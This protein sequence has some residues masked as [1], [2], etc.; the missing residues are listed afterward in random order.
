M[1]SHASR[2]ASAHDTQLQIETRCNAFE[3]AW[4]NGRN[5]HLEEFLADVAPAAR[6]QLLREL[7][8]LELFYR[9]D[10]D[11]ALLNDARLCE[12][13]PELMSEIPD[14]LKLLRERQW[15]RTNTD[16]VTNRPSSSMPDVDP[17]ISL[18]RRS[19][20]GSRGSR[21]LHIRCPH[22]SNPVELLTDTRL[23]SITCRTCGSAFSLVDSDDQTRQAPTL[24][25]I[26]RFEL[27]G[28]IG[29]GGFGTVWKA[30]D[31]ELERT[32]AVK[33]PRKGQ[34]APHEVEQ[35]LREARSAAQLRHP[36]I[37]PVHEVGREDDTIFI[38]SELIRG[39]S[40]CDWLS[41][42]T[43]GPKEAARLMATIADAVQHAHEKGIIHR[44]LKPSNMLMDELGQPHIMDF[45]LAKREV[46]EISMTLD[47][48]VL[49]TPAYMSPEQADGRG[50]WTDR[51]TD[52][53]SLGIIFFRMLTGELPFRGNAQMQIHKRITEDAPDPRGLNRFVPRDLSTI[54]LK[55][56]ERDPNRRFS[57]AKELADELRRFLGGEPI[58]SR[59][60]TRTERGIRWIKRNP[61]I[62][63]AALLTIVLAIAGPITAMVIAAQR[64]R[65][66]EL[67]KEVN[68]IIT[69]NTFDKQNEANTLAEL[70]SALDVWEGKSNP[71]SLGTAKTNEGPRK[72]FL[73]ELASKGEQLVA[74]WQS[75]ASDEQRAYGQLALAIIN[76]EAGRAAEAETHY[77]AAL[78]LLAQLSAK[79]PTETQYA[80]TIADCY[81]QLSRLHVEHDRARAA[82]DLEKSR[83]I[84]QSLAG[85]HSD[86]RLQ[87]ELLEAELDT[88][89]MKGGQAGVQNLARVQ[90]I[91]STLLGNLPKDPVKLYELTNFLAGR[92]PFLTTRKSTTGTAEPTAA[93]NANL[94]ETS[95]FGR[96]RE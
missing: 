46:G 28:R 33:I 9:R 15:E 76:D 22:C 69:R 75:T 65:L 44:D 30:R 54:C 49:G 23:E 47:G 93:V 25:R 74:P 24:K 70:R 18:G 80:A 55:C 94:D 8:I 66:T 62:S 67:V 11:G 78:E 16:G 83:T 48:Q 72:M 14:Q 20:S 96:S 27:V 63:A 43:P 6:A 51:R 26:G 85:R 59:P 36:N 10:E 90:Q 38:V 17:T 31:T 1:E 86:A 34:L 56:L 52:I 57:T 87:T 37:V 92:E 7:L 71:W 64:N 73:R 32:V 89:I 95:P 81:R 88:A 39:V 19:S 60:I 21:G 42:A 53:Y 61:A 2:P 40:L 45:G 12:L 4:Q 29:L 3:K 77:N 50:H 58:V 5:P 41:G 82:A 91:E 68:N 13:H 79:S 35:F 84:S